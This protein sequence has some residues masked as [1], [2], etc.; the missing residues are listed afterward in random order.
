[1]SAT[2]V[3]PS[4]NK[5]ILR[6]AFATAFLLMIPFVA[7]QYSDEVVWTAFDFVVAGVLLFGAGLTFEL[8]SRRRPGIAYR[9]GVAVAVFT[10]L[11]LVWA[12]L[13]VGL[14]G[15]EENPA[16]LMYFGVLAVAVIGCLIARFQPRGM[17]RALIAAAVVQM[18]VALI[19]QI[20]GQGLSYG[21]NGF[22]AAL[23]IGSAFLLQRAAH[24]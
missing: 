4:K 20:A 15:S 2:N 10:G 6:V 24:E 18:L 13:A 19:A 12:N 11:F 7:M 23:W 22:F 9:I 3:V 16:N 17:A 8:I 21:V 14:I 5:S 1:M